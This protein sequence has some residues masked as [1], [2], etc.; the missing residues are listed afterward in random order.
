LIGLARA[1]SEFFETLDCYS[2]FYDEQNSTKHNFSPI[3]MILLSS[4]TVKVVSKLNEQK[5]K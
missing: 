4:K 1:A 2:M 5:T 3:P